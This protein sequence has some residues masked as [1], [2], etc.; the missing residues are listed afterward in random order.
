MTVIINV[1]GSALPITMRHFFCPAIR[2]KQTHLGAPPFPRS[3]R[4]FVHVTTTHGGY[5]TRDLGLLDNGF[6]GCYH[7]LRSHDSLTPYS[8]A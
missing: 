4:A 8:Y 3:T 1:S 2:A 6:Q 5:L 7:T